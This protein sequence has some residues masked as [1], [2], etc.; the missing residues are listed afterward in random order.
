MARA[1]TRSFSLSWLRNYWR[2]PERPV[3]R[4]ELVPLDEPLELLD[5]PRVVPLLPRVDE[6]LD[7]PL[8]DP[9][10][11]EDRDELDR[12]ELD[13]DDWEGL[14]SVAPREETLLRSPWLD[15]LGR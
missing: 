9:D 1:S 10:Q 12:D 13:H 5:D 14:D 2:P 6:P 3:D 8:D 11:E 4:P 7:D 15:E